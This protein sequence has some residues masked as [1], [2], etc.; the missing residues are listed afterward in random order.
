[1]EHLESPTPNRRTSSARRHRPSRPKSRR[2]RWAIALGLAATLVAGRPAEAEGDPPVDLIAISVDGPS[3]AQPGDIVEIDFELTAENYTGTVVYRLLLGPDNPI[4][5]PSWSP[6]LAGWTQISWYW[7]QP[8][9][10]TEF[11][12]IPEFSEHF[13]PGSYWIYLQLDK[14]GGGTEA[15][16]SNNEVASD[17]IQFGSPP[18]IKAVSIAG[19][20]AAM[21]GDSTDL[22]I[23]VAGDHHV[24]LIQYRI[25]LSKDTEIT[26]QDPVVGSGSLNEKFTF[27]PGHDTVTMTIP[28]LPPGNYHWGLTVDTVPG[29][30]ETSDN[31]VAGGTF[32]LLESNPDLIAAGVC[33]S[34]ASGFA[35]EPIQLHI[36]ALADNFDGD[37]PFEV[38]LSP[39]G[40]QGSGGL[41]ILQGMMSGAGTE[42]HSVVLPDLQAGTYELALEIHAVAGEIDLTNNVVV[43]GTVVVLGLPD[44]CV[45]DSGPVAFCT[46]SDDEAP[47]PIT[48]QVKNCGDVNTML[49]WG[50]SLAID[51]AWLSIA[52]GSGLLAA[53]ASA[54]LTFTCNPVGLPPGEHQATVSIQNL[55]NPE[56][57]EDIEVRLCVGAP[58]FLPG[59]R[60][61]GTCVGDTETF[62]AR[63]DAVAGMVL[64]VVPKSLPAVSSLELRIVDE[65]T[66]APIVVAPLQSKGGKGKIKV[67]LP[68]TAT[69]R[70]EIANVGSVGNFAIQ[71]KAKFPKAAKKL[72][73]WL[74]GADGATQS[75]SVLALPNSLLRITVK[76]GS[77]VA[78]PGLSVT[79]VGG[80][81]HGPYA[82]PDSSKWKQSLIVESLGTYAVTIDGLVGKKAAK[83]QVKVVQPVGTSTLLLQPVLD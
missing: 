29:E 54:D 63:F 62:A 16:Y 4:T 75:R 17:P 6:V 66:E 9:V 61:T 8:Y 42:Q 74:D 79:I 28:D 67:I 50:T 34:P 44:L 18:N 73:A 72:S 59:D 56:D 46:M 48:R 53:G 12:K 35:G 15:D 83:L 71:T 41:A 1:M 2:G 40:T 5:Y 14:T 33:A 22:K 32:Q 31:A 23:Q 3:H 58:K 69:Y 82:V 51:A 19:P 36:T 30:E 26:T 80:T 11:V 76:P 77:V 52:P 24:G 45:D 43:G 27:P 81:S 10:H 25:R 70:L 37:L 21:A 60:L 47:E 68:E 64:K 65:S 38:R 39:S 20:E 57:H 78:A 7:P 49:A 55:A 13:E